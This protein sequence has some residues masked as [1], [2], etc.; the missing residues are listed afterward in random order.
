MHFRERLRRRG[1]KKITSRKK[2]KI[3]KWPDLTGWERDLFEGAKIFYG[4]YHNT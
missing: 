1:K 2:K 3:I 4:S